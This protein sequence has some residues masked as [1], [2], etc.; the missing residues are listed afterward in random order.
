MKIGYRAPAKQ[1]LMRYPADLV[2]ISYWKR[3]GPNLGEIREMAAL[4]RE[5]GL[6]YVIH[7]VF[8]PLSETRPGPREENLKELTWLAGLA[9]LGLILHDETLADGSRLS[10]ESLRLYREAVE[11]LSV[12]CSFSIENAN[13]VPDADWFWKEIGGS[14][15]LDL[16]HFESSGID[17]VRKVRSLPEELLERVEYVHMHRK[18]GEHGGILDHWPLTPDCREVQALELLFTRKRDISVILEVNEMDQV[19]ESLEILEKIRGSV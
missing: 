13:N 16:G 6:P 7:P 3:F 14:I 10:G 11:E 17:S 9:D 5:H 19:G 18:N 8:T 1:E 12:L 2:Q 4:C 15:T